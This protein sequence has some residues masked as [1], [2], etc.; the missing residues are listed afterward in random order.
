MNRIRFT[1]SMAVALTALV[2]AMSGVG[3]AASQLSHDG[4]K[5]KSAKK[6]KGKRGPA[7]PQGPQGA[8]GA[9]GDTGAPG[10]NGP[11]VFTGRLQGLNI[12]QDSNTF[13]VPSGQSVIVVNEFDASSI[14][15]PNPLTAKSLTVNLTAAPGGTALRFFYLMIN[16]SPSTPCVVLSANTNC[17]IPLNAAIPAN[18]TISIRSEVS[19]GAANP[20]N[21]RFAWT[22]Q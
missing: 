3:Y 21:A 16:N 17:S 8:P 5:A 14:N 6:S 9:K 20:A 18:A 13:G 1:P 4:G 11:S 7:G 10:A 15:G 2:F 12:A 19:S 22:A